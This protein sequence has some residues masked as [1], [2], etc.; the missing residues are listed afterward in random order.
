MW[1]FEDRPGRRDLVLGVAAGAVYSVEV[2]A[3]STEPVAMVALAPLVVGAVWVRRAQPFLAMAAVLG[4]WVL[5]DRVDASFNEDG[6]L[7]W[8]VTWLLAHYALGRWTHG[9]AALLAPV[10]SAATAVALGWGDIADSGVPDL[11]YFLS[12][13]LLPYGAGIGVRMRQQRVD[14]LHTE[15]RRL[16]QRQARIAREAE[17]AERARIARELHDVV[18]HAITVTVLQARGARRKLG[19]DDEAVRA[20]LDAIERTNEAAL[21]DMRR[22]L[23]VLRDTDVAVGH[24]PQPSLERVQALLDDVRR[25]GLSVE[26]RVTGDEVE[27]PPGVDLSAYRILQEALTN[28][29]RHG[30][31]AVATTVHLERGPTELVVRVHNTPGGQGAAGPGAGHGLVS[32]RERVTVLG[33]DLSLRDDEQGFELRARLPYSVVSE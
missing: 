24:A 28:V 12:V 4:C 11:A 29:L 13:S 15:N 32:V 31:E 2:A 16:E 23:A 1:W 3:R 10:A 33:G 25:A 14:D 17:A 20:A 21:G 7:A 6:S 30:G 18:S 26:L 9:K 19:Q 27:V 8:L 22:L 5:G